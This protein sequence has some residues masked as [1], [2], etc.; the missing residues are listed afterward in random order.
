MHGPRR[1]LVPVDFE[2][3]SRSVLETAAL[4]AQHFSS[5]LVV[6]HVWEP[7]RL[8]AAD[9]L[10]V[11]PGWDTVSLERIALAEAGRH[12]EALVREQ[13]PAALTASTRLEVG[14]VAS[15]VVRIA[16]AEQAE[17]IVVGTHGRRG[18]SRMLLGSV[19]HAV[20]SHAKVPVLTVPTGGERG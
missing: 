16:E 12:M 17:L 6:L 20:I 1:I 15:T 18:L 7:P 3:T 8:L 4:W 14:P 13:I 11:A 5:S 10:Y 19:A 2:E 9:T